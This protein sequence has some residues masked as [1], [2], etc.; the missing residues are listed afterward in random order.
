MNEAKGKLKAAHWKKQEPV[1]KVDQRVQVE[2]NVLKDSPFYG[3]LFLS[4]L[5]SIGV[6]PS[7][8]EGGGSTFGSAKSET[9]PPGQSG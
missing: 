7:K 5:A 1:P 2:E 9:E 8:V 4:L 3:I 6:C